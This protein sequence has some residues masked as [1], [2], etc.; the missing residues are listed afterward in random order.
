MPAAD[1][2]WVLAPVWSGALEP[3]EVRLPS[4]DGAL[5]EPG[6]PV[7]IGCAYTVELRA[8]DASGQARTWP[9]RRLVVRSLACAAR[10]EQSVRQRG[11]RRHGDQR[12]E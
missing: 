9:E 3:R 4:T 5:D 8:P 7:A 6:E 2:P 11:A 12:A 10:Q 1:L